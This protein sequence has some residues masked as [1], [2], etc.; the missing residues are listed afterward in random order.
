MALIM[1][2]KL[3]GSP[4]AVNSSQIEYI[5]L[6]PESKITMMNGKYHI[7]QETQEEIIEKIVQFNQ[8]IFNGLRV[9]V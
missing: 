7:V 2:T 1:L 4:V 6:I 9:E 3:N 8:K 5:D